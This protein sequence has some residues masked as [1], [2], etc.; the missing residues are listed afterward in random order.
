MELIGSR[1]NLRLHVGS[2]SASE[3]SGVVIGRDLDLLQRIERRVHRNDAEKSLI[4]T[5]AVQLSVI[6]ILPQAVHV[7][8]AAGGL[9]VVASKAVT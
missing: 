6:R 8:S 7:N 9:R 5:H 4:V 3:F 1:L 2:A